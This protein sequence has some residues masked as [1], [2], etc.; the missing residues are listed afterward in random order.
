MNLTVRP[1]D[2]EHIHRVWPLVEH[3]IIDALN[4]G[5]T[6]EAR[7]YNA[8]HV[9]VFVTNG[10]WLLIVVTDENNEIHG[11]AT[12]SFL[13]Y[14]LHRVAFITA[15]G[16]RLVTSQENAAQLFEIFRA[17]GAMTVEAAARDDILRLWK[18][19]GL[20]LKYHIISASL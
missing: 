20:E 16:G 18:K 14:P 10:T 13:N 4:K 17:N 5:V 3:Y 19:Y 9:R 7:N 2:V 1:V 12:V 11:C 8:E 15:L 6:E